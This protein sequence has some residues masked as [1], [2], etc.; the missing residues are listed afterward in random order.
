MERAPVENDARV[1]PSIHPKAQCR[2]RLVDCTT[3]EFDPNIRKIQRGLTQRLPDGKIRIRINPR[4]KAI[5]DFERISGTL[6]HE[7]VHAT[8]K[9]LDN[10]R[11]RH[12]VDRFFR[13]GLTGRGPWFR[14]IAQ[15]IV[16]RANKDGSCTGWVLPGARQAK[17]LVPKRNSNATQERCGRDEPD[18]VVADRYK[19]S[20]KKEARQSKNNGSSSRSS[21][22][23]AKRKR[24]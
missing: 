9:L 23:R 10:K 7:M 18:D 14:Q 3:F 1:P 13:R 22:G 2:S 24:G 6:L 8:G 19:I 20:A 5:A 11:N 15:D 21:K 16:K 4:P 12:L 17:S